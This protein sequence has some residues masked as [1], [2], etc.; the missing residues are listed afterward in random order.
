MFG[1]CVFEIFYLVVKIRGIIVIL[2]KN[3]SQVLLKISLGYIFFFGKIKAVTFD[4][5]KIDG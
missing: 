3:L 4:F 2:L 5:M 1:L